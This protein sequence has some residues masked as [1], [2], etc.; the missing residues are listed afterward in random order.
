MR[1]ILLVVVLAVTACT[2]FPEIEEANRSAAP[3]GDPPPL[4][5]YTE[6]VATTA[7]VP[8]TTPSS[9]DDLEARAAA[10][11]ARAAILRQPADDIDALRARL[12]AS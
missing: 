12:D 8:T 3:V 1:A 5:P 9:T 11:R 2:N 10:L 4:L 6:L 7:G